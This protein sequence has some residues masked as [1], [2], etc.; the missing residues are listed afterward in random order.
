MPRWPGQHTLPAL[1][2]L[3]R[4]VAKNIPPTLAH[5]KG[6]NGGYA[7]MS[8]LITVFCRRFTVHITLYYYGH[9]R[10]FGGE[11]V[12]VSHDIWRHVNVVMARRLSHTRMLSYCYVT[13]L[14]ST[15]A[16][17]EHFREYEATTV[18]LV[19]VCWS[20]IRFIAASSTLSVVVGAIVNMANA[21]SILAHDGEEAGD[22]I[23][24][25]TMA[26]MMALL[27]R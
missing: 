12:W 23:A 10:L 7:A 5:Y 25:D 22:A 18:V 20:A 17:F 13:A 19:N 4:Q 11:Q 14:L 9:Y 24:I 26:P 3:W 1:A 6:A 8:S 16:S 27:L 2:T 15:L 21:R